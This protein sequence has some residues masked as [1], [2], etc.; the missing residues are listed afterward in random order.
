MCGKGAGPNEETYVPEQ[1]M[2]PWYLFLHLWNGYTPTCLALLQGC[3]E[4]HKGLQTGKCEWHRVV[5]IGG[6]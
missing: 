5:H 4:I 1:I 2:S 6:T 3:C